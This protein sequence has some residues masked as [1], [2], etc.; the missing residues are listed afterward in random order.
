MDA[1][2]AAKKALHAEDM[3]HVQKKRRVVGNNCAAECATDCPADCGSAA[4]VAV[5]ATPKL[6]ELGCCRPSPLVCQDAVCATVT[7][8]A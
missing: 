2:E 6:I 7:N 5:T 3:G 8:R 4:E 1:E